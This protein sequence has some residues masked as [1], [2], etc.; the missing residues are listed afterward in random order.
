MHGVETH[1]GAHPHTTLILGNSTGR[2]GTE[3]FWSEDL[4]KIAGIGRGTIVQVI[5]EVTV[6]RG[7]RR[8]LRIT[9]IRPLP[10]GTIE[11]RRLLPSVGDVAP[12]WERLDHWRA[13]VRG[14]RLRAVLALFYDDPEFRARY[15]GCPGSTRGH[16]AALGGL[17]KHTVEVATIARAIGR[18]AGADL[19]LLLAGAL[20][21]D[22]GKLEAYD[23]AG[24]SGGFEPTE[25]NALH[26]HVVLGALLLDR[27]VRSSHPMACT[28][29]ELAILIHLVLSHHGKPEY[30]AP[31]PPRTLEAEILHWADNASA[32]SASMAEALRNA[33]NFAPGAEIS[34][35]AAELDR[36]R[37]Y[38]GRSDWGAE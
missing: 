20:L 36:R 35:P 2:I 17:L 6:Y 19:D 4:P 18:T 3:P 37:L 5:G 13:A 8:Q 26:G 28:E 1:G 32:K 12:Y 7:R 11:P 23:W 16:H 21:H 24:G 38:R 10:A 22:L 25:L 27:M 14:P 34:E 9:S 29:Q 15:E 31:V 33:S 30:G